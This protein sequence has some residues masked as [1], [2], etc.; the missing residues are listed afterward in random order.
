MFQ[1]ICVCI[2][3]QVELA[4]EELSENEKLLKINKAFGHITVQ[5]DAIMSLENEKNNEEEVE[6]EVTQNSKNNTNNSGNH[7]LPFKFTCEKCNLSLTYGEELE[8]HIQSH[9]QA[10]K[11]FICTKCSKTFLNADDLKRHEAT[12][13][14]KEKKKHQ[15]IEQCRFCDKIY[16][17]QHL[18][19]MHVI[20][21]HLHE[22]GYDLQALDC[23]ECEEKFA[24]GALLNYHKKRSHV[25][26]RRVKS[27]HEP[28]AC[29]LCQTVTQSLAN[30]MKSEHPD[31]PAYQCMYC[32]EMFVKLRTRKTHIEKH[33]RQ[34]SC[35]YCTKEVENHEMLMKHLPLCERAPQTHREAWSRKIKDAHTRIYNCTHCKLK[36]K[37]LNHLRKHE[38]EVHG[39]Y[40][41]LQ[42]HIC[43]KKIPSNCAFK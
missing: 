38:K 3:P 27:Y 18:V 12:H 4:D 34:V 30:H 41:E 15:K 10:E 20:R 5:E 25:K 2:P 9:Y 36:F 31:S 1:S 7:S 28:K 33:H 19:D 13:T 32:S 23:D 11:K 14:S 40:Q 43:L 21:E 42:C 17:F 8:Q 26:G 16:N 6:V 39:T 37:A 35:K 24:T 22:S 29:P